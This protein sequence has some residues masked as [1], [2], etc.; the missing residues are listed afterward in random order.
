ME[1]GQCRLLGITEHD[2]LSKHS[3]LTRPVKDRSNIDIN[4]STGA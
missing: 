1:V 3:G 4:I 2:S